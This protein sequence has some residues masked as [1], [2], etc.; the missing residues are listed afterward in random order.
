MKQIIVKSILHSI[1]N[2]LNNST[3]EKK[4]SDISKRHLLKPHFIPI[5]YRILGGILQSM[6]IQFGNF[7]EDVISQIIQMYKNNNLLHLS[8]QKN[9]Q[10][11][12]SVKAREYI[13]NYIAECQNNIFSDSIL[14]NKFINLLDKLRILS[15]EGPY[16]K[17]KHDIDLLFNNKGVNYIL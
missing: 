9:H 5:K 4:L 6:N 10:F 8:G 17:I 7:L 2:L 12:Q 13:D 3:S 11:K 14:E 16:T 1:D 15:S